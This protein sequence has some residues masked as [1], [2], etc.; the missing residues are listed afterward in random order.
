[1]SQDPSTIEDVREVGANLPQ[2]GGATVDVQV[3]TARRFPRSITQFVHSA[4]EM[5]TLTPEIAASCVYAIPR[6]GKTIEGPSARLAEIVA[7]AWGN[8]RIQAG[9]TSDDGRFVVARGEAWDVQTNVAIGFEVKRKITN[10]G[11][12]T[13]SDDMIVVTGNAAA[14][15]ALRNAVFKTVPSSFWR[16][17]YLKCRQVI[18]GDARTFSSRRDDMLKAFA[19][20]GVTEARLCGAIGLKG[21]ADVTLEHM[22][23]LAG[24]LNALKEGETSIEEA[25]PEHA[26]TPTAAPRKSQQAGFS[27]IADQSRKVAS[28]VISAMVDKIDREMTDGDKIASEKQGDGDSGLEQREA[29]SRDMPS[30]PAGTVGGSV[31]PASKDKSTGTIVNVNERPNGTAMIMLSTGFRCGTSDKVLIQWAVGYAGTETIVQLVCD[32]PRTPAH[33]AKLVEIIAVDR[34]PGQ[35]G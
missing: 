33:A 6:D 4:T 27:P 35:E 17:I 24:I 28:E 34:E 20:M 8:L 30:A 7:S 31:S 32:P 12:A 18:A 13:F 1:M 16:P 5:A 23:T 11:G 29:R 21:K 10:R 19:V 15:I 25:F 14:S 22:A 26:S 2:A 9:A 3:S